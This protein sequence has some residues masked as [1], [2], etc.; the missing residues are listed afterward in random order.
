[1][2]YPE[3][4]K[5]KAAEQQPPPV[6]YPNSPDIYQGYGHKGLEESNPSP[7]GSKY[8]HKGT[9]SPTEAK[10]AAPDDATAKGGSQD[11]PP[12]DSRLKTGPKRGPFAGPV[13]R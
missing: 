8:S 10:T 5:Q 1:M 6:L 4:D 11:T 7:G 2:N 12:A 9:E 13:A 3:M